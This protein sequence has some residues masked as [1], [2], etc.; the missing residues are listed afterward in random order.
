MKVKLALAFVAVLFAA[1]LARADSVFTVTIS[2]TTMEGGDTAALS[3]NWDATTQAISDINLVIGNAPGGDN[4]AG[5]TWSSA[6]PY[7]IPP[8]QPN[9]GGL[10]LLDL[11]GP[12]GSYFQI[13]QGN[14]GL[15]PLMPVT[16]E[17]LVAID[18]NCPGSSI[19]APTGG[20]ALGFGDIEFGAADAF[21]T[22]PPS[23]PT[24]EPSS[25]LLSAVGLAALSGLARKFAQSQSG[26]A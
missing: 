13:D 25:L 1:T 5:F 22:D 11:D 6:A 18:L 2:Q 24:P 12:G 19:G 26:Q 20:C 23:V 16:G 17:Q 8:G 10:F 3:F 9:A 7:F 15:P 4:A 21:I 14:Y